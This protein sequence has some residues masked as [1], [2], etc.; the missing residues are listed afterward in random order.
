MKLPDAASPGR[1]PVARVAARAAMSNTQGAVG[2][3]WAI[4][5]TLSL[6]LGGITPP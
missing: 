4:L 6:L 5:A 3:M 2:K 1:D